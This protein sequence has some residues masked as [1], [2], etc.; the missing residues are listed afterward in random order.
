MVAF[1]L[2]GGPRSC[3]GAS[4]PPP[5]RAGGWAWSDQGEAAAR[6]L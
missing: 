5:N 2:L 4:A 1:G 3:P 6:Q